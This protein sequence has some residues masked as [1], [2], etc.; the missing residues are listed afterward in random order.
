MPKKSVQS[1]CHWVRLIGLSSWFN[2][3]PYSFAHGYSSVD[4]QAE[5]GL[6]GFALA[7]D[8]LA[9]ANTSVFNASVSVFVSEVS[10]SLSSYS[11]SIKSVTNICF[12]KCSVTSESEH[13]LSEFSDEAEPGCARRNENET[14]EAV[15]LVPRERVQQWSAEQIG[16]VPQF[17]EKVSRVWMESRANCELAPRKRSVKPCCR[18]GTRFGHF[19]TLTG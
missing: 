5:V 13:E 16:D 18:L 12:V 17:R 9:E 2:I 10:Y 15:T 11:L 19:V 14:V 4:E 3:S 1:F 8:R 6:R 7:F